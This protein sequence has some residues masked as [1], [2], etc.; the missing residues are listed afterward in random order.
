MTLLRGQLEL[1]SGS[2]ALSQ[3]MQEFC[4]EDAPRCPEQAKQ[5]E[6]AMTGDAM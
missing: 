1:M 2:F 4:T 3:F 6:H 5:H